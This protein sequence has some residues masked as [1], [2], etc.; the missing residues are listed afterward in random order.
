MTNFSKGRFVA[1]MIGCGLLAGAVDVFAEQLE[2]VV[3]TAQ[4]R[5]ESVQDIPVAVS[6]V[7]G[8]LLDHWGV[9]SLNEIWA[10]VPNMQISQPY[11]EVQPIFSIRGVN[12]SDYNSN[13]SSPIGVYVDEAY[14]GAIFTHGLNF[15]D[16]DR[17]EVLRGPQ[18]T[19]YGKNTTGGAINIITRTPDLDGDLSGSIRAGFGNNNLRNVSGA[20][21]GALVPG[22]FAA[23]FAF[24]YREDDGHYRNALGGDDVAQTDFKGGRLTLNWLPADS[25]STILKI[26]SSS[27]TPRSHPPRNEGR[28]PVPGV[29]A[30]DITGYQR[31]AE[32]DFHAGEFNKVGNTDIQMDLIT[33]RM[34]WESADFSIVS[35]TSWYDAD[36]FQAV[37]TDGSPNTLLQIDWESSTDAVGQD[38]RFVSDF[39][40]AFD[41]IA[42][43]YFG[44]E[45]LAM[46][47]LLTLYE[48][49]TVLL[50]SPLGDLLAEFGQ[51]DQRL[52]H[53]KES[54]AFY[55]QFRFELSDRLGMDFGLRY[56]RDENRL[57]YINLSRLDFG[58]NPLGSWV[59]GN[60]TGTLVDNP[61]LPPEFDPG[62]I[63]FYIDGPYTL[64]SA[65][66]LKRTE[67]EWTGKLSLDYA[68]SRH[69]LGY[70]SYSR[71]YRSGSFNGGL[72][73]VPRPLSGAYA[74][75]EFLDAW[76]LGLKSE[77]ATGK[78]RINAAT[79]YYD[80]TD[81][82]FVNVV[83]VSTFLENAGGSEIF[84]LEV[85]LWAHLTDRLSLQTSL[86]WLDTEYTKLKLA[87]TLTTDPDDQIDLAGNELI[88]APE[89][90]FSLAADYAVPVSDWGLFIAHLNVNYQDDQWFS[91]YNDKIGYDQIRQDAYWLANGR[92]SLQFCA[93]DRCLLSAWIKNI[94]DEEYDSYA[95]NVQAGFGYDYYLSGMPRTYGLE[96][97]YRF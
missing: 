23:R 24:D 82:Q 57:D 49:P 86:G 85:E 8:E 42:G 88:S 61:F 28:I 50:G 74:A 89:L 59:P 34:T 67:K 7:T 12:M 27:S 71:G 77:L 11:G 91:A 36:Y 68:I 5:A 1:A 44:R 17:I 45:D 70:A 26:S 15:Y 75:P 97:E 76:E 14:V 72:Y 29:G 80:Y 51:V 38:L 63:G 52:N 47:N 40:G 22:V 33:L 84:G 39:S 78:V 48:S 93:D 54:Y 43:L 65:P 16:V 30:I 79:F 21:E 83:G 58:G 3:V 81:Q 4:R 56:T 9:I 31:P 19:L 92:L 87:N 32:L 6:A 37:D 60:I 13:Q 2:E 10:Q 46:T 25:F 66:R 94:F 96:F 69:L 73:Y 64:D 53:F 35:V 55:S 62:G 41:F 18:G 20:I 95:I 90:N